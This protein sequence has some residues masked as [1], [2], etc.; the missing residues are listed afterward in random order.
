MSSLY[1]HIP[2]CKKACYYCDFHFSTNLQLKSAMVEAI[3]KEIE[4]RK[5]YLG[6]QAL[7]TIYF[8]GGTPSLLE[9]NELAQ[10]FQSIHQ[11]FSLAPN[12]EITLEAN[13]DDLQAASLAHW[14][15]VGVNRLSMGVQSFN[16]AH[17]KFLNRIHTGQAAHDTIKMAQDQGIDNISIDL[18]YAIPA[19]SHE[20]WEK[21]LALTT[22]LGIPHLSS[23]CLTIEEQTAFG[24]WLKKDMIQP[25]DEDFA[26]EQF[27]IM[28]QH[29]EQNDYEHYEISNFARDG[30]YSKHNTN[31]WKKGNYLGIGPSA[32][33]YNQFSRQFNIRNNAR[34]IKA[35]NEGRVPGEIEYLS[36]TDQV[37]EFIM[38]NLRTSWGCNL[39]EIHKKYNINLWK[40]HEE[41]LHNYLRQGLVIHE[42]GVL[43]LTRKGKLF[44]DIISSDLF[45]TDIVQ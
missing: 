20:I 13:P 16:D 1:I 18:I 7:E 35:L 25:I 5:D 33:S 9:E 21:D 3:T 39:E 11:F 36:Q 2:F 17:L 37:N 19:P 12:I 15:K 29:F 31:Y 24:V 42:E 8:G 28:I 27:E 23:Y 43:Y 34:Y 44:A 30:K 38:T 4:L 10:I 32:H 14:Q 22:S 6:T 40:S 26:A 41:I 45:V